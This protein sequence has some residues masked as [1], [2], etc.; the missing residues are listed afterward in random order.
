MPVLETRRL[1]RRGLYTLL[2]KDLP[3]VRSHVI[4]AGLKLPPRKRSSL[5]QQV[6]GAVALRPRRCGSLER[7]R[8]ASSPIN[9]RV[10]EGGCFGVVVRKKE[11]KGFREREMTTWVARR[12]SLQSTRTYCS[13]NGAIAMQQSLIST[14]NLSG[15][16]LKNCKQ[17]RQDLFST[18]A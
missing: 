5:H 8:L 4:A 10:S 1:L 11:M 7:G 14:I 16:I 9:E 18:F 13:L 6:I 12:S 2:T 17:R 3:S 15:H